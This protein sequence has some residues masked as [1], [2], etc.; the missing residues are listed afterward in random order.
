M[1]TRVGKIARLPLAIRDELNA[2]LLEGESGTKI[3]PWLNSLEV[4][5]KVLGEDFE[6]L[7]V[8]DA[9]LSDWRHG[10]YQDWLKK[11]DRLEHTR[12]LAQMSA[13]LAKANG[14]NLTEGASTILGGKILELLEGISDL[15]QVATDGTPEQLREHMS[16]MADA[17]VN[18]T[19]GVSRLRQGDQANASLKLNKARL[20][21]SGEA[22]KLEREKF[23]LLLLKGLT[24]MAKLAKAREI[25]ESGLSN[26]EK[27]AALRQAFF[28][29]IDALEASGEVELPK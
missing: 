6:G 5:K 16:A 17:V 28:S 9:N 27:I 21:Q 23:E 2:R 1:V 14:G 15:G 20:A 3:L 11:R 25:N 26:S 4:V 10:G 18:L 29:D 13:K 7:A 24:D 12:E 22:L 19:L 8:N